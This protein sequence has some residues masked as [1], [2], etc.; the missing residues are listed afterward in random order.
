PHDLPVVQPYVPHMPFPGHLK[1]Q[2]DNPYKTYETVCMI[3]I[4]EKIHKKKAHEDERDMD[5]SWDITIKDIERLRQILTPTIHTLPNLELVVQSYMPRGPVRNEAKV[6]KEE[7]LE[8]N[9]PLQNGV[10]KPLTPQTVHITPL[11]DD[12]VTPTTNPI[13]DKHLN[14]F[15]KD[16]FDMT[17]V[18]EM[19]TLWKI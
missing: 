4:L 10:M 2:K 15:G 16:F 3:G 13:L 5:D 9:I 1:K 18:D 19:V 17:R 6:I 7:E 8:Y 11:D 14:E 12:Y